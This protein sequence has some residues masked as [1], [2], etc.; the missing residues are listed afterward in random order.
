MAGFR[1]EGL[2]PGKTVTLVCRAMWQVWWMLQYTFVFEP[3]YKVG[4]IF[5]ILPRRERGSERLG[6]LPKVTEPR[7][8]LNPGL[9]DP[10]AWLFPTLQSSF[11][12]RP[13][14]GFSGTRMPSFLSPCVSL[15]RSRWDDPYCGGA[16]VE[17][18]LCTQCSTEL[19]H[20]TL[21]V[22]LRGLRRQSLR[23]VQ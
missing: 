17:D 19:F 16:F 21:V 22:A 7:Q 5:F 6:N 4:I 18:L 8:D 13:A 2:G 14:E 15:S 23:E 3:P 11:L 20:F 9:S 12:I 10:K 1:E